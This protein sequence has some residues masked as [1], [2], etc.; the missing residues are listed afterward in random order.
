MSEYIVSSTSSRQVLQAKGV[1]CLTRCAE[2]AHKRPSGLDT[3]RP[4]W[5]KLMAMYVPPRGYCFLGDV[6]PE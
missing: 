5:C 6:D 3:L 1:E 4:L 2:C